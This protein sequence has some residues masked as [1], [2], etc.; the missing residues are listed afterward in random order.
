[1]SRLTI[2]DL[3]TIDKLINQ[4]KEIIKSR[5]NDIEIVKQLKNDTKTTN[6]MIE[7]N[8]NVIRES[9]LIL[10]GLTICQDK[11]NK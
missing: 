1:M 4:Q 6:E 5:E 2:Q 10:Y 11:V 8:K 7:L 3:S 9:E